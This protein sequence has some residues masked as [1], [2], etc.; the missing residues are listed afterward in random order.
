MCASPDI[1]VEISKIRTCFGYIVG[2]KRNQQRETA[3]VETG[4]NVLYLTY[5]A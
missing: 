4:I 1:E 5:D 3:E 2:R